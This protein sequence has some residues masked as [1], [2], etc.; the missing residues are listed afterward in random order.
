M[1]N[2]VL[3]LWLT[4]PYYLYI[5][6][7]I[8]IFI[9]FNTTATLGMSRALDIQQVCLIHWLDLWNYNAT[10]R[11]VCAITLS[12]AASLEKCVGSQIQYEI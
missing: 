12:V 4:E 6:L 7:F 3:F 8:I 10:C 5:W 1:Q 9:S 2:K 11:L